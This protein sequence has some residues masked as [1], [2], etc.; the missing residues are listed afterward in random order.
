[1]VKTSRCPI[2]PHT[3]ITLYKVSYYQP[4]GP[5]FAKTPPLLR[6][7]TL[8]TRATIMRPCLLSPPRSLQHAVIISEEENVHVQES[9]ALRGPS[10]LRAALYS[11]LPVGTQRLSFTTVTYY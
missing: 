11:F 2:P 5:F 3:L 6:V 8:R 7:N 9:R 4:S 10:R 1:M